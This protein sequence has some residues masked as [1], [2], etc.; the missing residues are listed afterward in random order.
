MTYTLGLAV[1]CA[2]GMLW[3]YRFKQNLFYEWSHKLLPASLFTVGDDRATALDHLGRRLVSG[4]AEEPLEAV[5]ML[6]MALP[7]GLVGF[8]QARHMR[9]RLLYGV[10]TAVL[11]AATFAT[12]RKSAMIA[13]IVIG[14]T[15]AYFRRRD[16]LKLAPLS[17][18]AVVAVSVLSPGA[19]GSTV[20]QFTRS[21]RLTVPTVS[22][23]TADYDAV[24]PDVWSH[25]AFGRG[26]GSYNHQSYRIL[27]S[28]IL[29][30]IIET[31]VLGLL[32]F[33]LMCL[34]VVLSAR[35]TIALRDREWAPLALIGA[36]AAMGFLVSATLYDLMSFPHGTYIFLYIAGLTA[37]VVNPRRRRAPAAAVASP[38]PHVGRRHRPLRLPSAGRPLEHA[39]R[40]HG[41]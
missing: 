38:P 32:F 25:I 24:R 8:I 12:Y 37:V 5:T 21:D 23:R 3:E 6:C 35:A 2:L 18:V 26:W 29:Q 17:L 33:I 11:L 22:D 10:A 30:R 40:A 41:S 9:G 31:G 13:P 27:D 4:P 28:D 14:L 1:I 36:A 19:I 16:L 34:S 7:I 39:G 20:S 15:V